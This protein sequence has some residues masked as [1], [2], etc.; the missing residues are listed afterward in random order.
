MRSFSKRA[1]VVVAATLALG[2]SPALAGPPV[3][4]HPGVEGQTGFGPAAWSSDG[5]SLVVTAWDRATLLALGKDGA[6]V[7]LLSA[8]RGA[9]FH[10]VWAA[11]GWL[12]KGVTWDER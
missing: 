11:G 1:G 7:R 10:P 8:E 2:V 3:G 9:G 6:A 4:W 12:F 5:A